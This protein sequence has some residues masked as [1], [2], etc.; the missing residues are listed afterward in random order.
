MWQLQMHYNLKAARLCGSRYGLFWPILYCSSAQTDVAELLI[1][2]VTH[3]YSLC[4][5]REE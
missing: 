1:K 5:L 3:I 2:S 4:K